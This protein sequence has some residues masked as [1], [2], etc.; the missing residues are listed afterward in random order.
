MGIVKL[1]VEEPVVK[2]PGL[3]VVVLPAGAPLTANDTVAVK[4]VPGVT[5]AVK[6][7]LPPP[8]RDC[9]DGLAEI[10]KLGTTVIVRVGG[11]GSATPLL[12]VTVREATEV[13]VAEYATAPGFC[14][15]LTPG[16]PWGNTHE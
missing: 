12:S 6:L 4:P 13:P 15:V 10:A 5:V 11:F 3:K 2:E 14:R 16:V 9:D 8:T 1:S 7:V